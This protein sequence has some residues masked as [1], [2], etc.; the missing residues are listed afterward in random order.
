MLWQ[1]FGLPKDQRY[2]VALSGGADSMALLIA[3]YHALRKFASNG[4]EEVSDLI[5]ALHF[6]HQIHPDSDA[7]QSACAR[8]CTELKI[9]FDSGK[10]DQPPG[11]VIN[12]GNAREARYRWLSEVVES[13]QV[14]LTAHH[15]DDQAETVMMH[16]LQGH[17][18]TRLKG[19]P[20]VRPLKFGDPRKVYRPLLEFPRESLRQLLKEHQVQWINDPTNQDLRVTR[21][22]VRAQL[23]P[24]IKER[25]PDVLSSIAASAGNLSRVN[26]L[27]DLSLEKSLEEIETPEAKRVFCLL[28]PLKIATLL[29]RSRFEFCQLIR[30]WI[31]KAGLPAPTEAQLS[32]LH[33]QLRERHEKTVPPEAETNYLR[34]K[35]HWKR[36]NIISYGRYLYLIPDLVKPPSH[37]ISCTI[38]SQDLTNYLSVTFLK[39]KAG[40]ISANLVESGELE[41]CWRKG[42][43]K[44]NLP[45]REHRSSL[46][47]VLQQNRIP[48][49][50]RD[51][52]P[53][54]KYRGEVV[55]V[56]GVGISRNFSQSDKDVNMLIPQFSLS[57]SRIKSF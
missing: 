5:T 9:K 12:E 21:N 4:A 3:L 34:C 50:E 10:W 39:T 51:H 11:Q 31:H 44:V 26:Q 37:S 18:L 43:E 55:W 13:D 29:P 30:R 8:C 52:L 23:M 7:W 6:N 48:E 14:L 38:A 16:L 54:L 49:W 46:K 19:I 35:L 2:A 57:K 53:F 1:D 42:G 27:L 17:G 24:L 22:F 33:Q 28:P 45:G 56:S 36:L 32:T 47:K 41:W 20:P 15:A 40:G 25:W